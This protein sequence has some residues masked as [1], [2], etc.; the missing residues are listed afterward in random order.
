MVS[1][2]PEY[3]KGSSNMERHAQSILTLIVVALLIWVGTTTLDVSVKIARLEVQVNAMQ[4][5]MDQPNSTVLLLIDQN[6]E[7]R[8]RML[9]LEEEARRIEQ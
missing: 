5:Q 4:T 3:Q 8:G 9:K 2:T 6:K 7:L 1:T